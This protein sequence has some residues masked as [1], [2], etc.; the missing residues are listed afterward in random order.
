MSVSPLYA[1]AG[2]RSR[3][4]VVVTRNASVYSEIARTM[5]AIGSDRVVHMSPTQLLKTKGA[6]FWVIDA[7]V[8]GAQDLIRELLTSKRTEGL[9]L[10]SPMLASFNRFCVRVG[11]PALLMHAAVEAP[12]REDRP[13]SLTNREVEIVRLI[14]F[15]R[16]NDEI[17]D[18]LGIT[19]LTVKSH[20]ARMLRKSGARDRCHLVLLA[21]RAR[22]IE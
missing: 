13:L 12:A 3:P 9:V 14:S 17:G 1:T 21:L 15:G 16:T 22:L 11:V 8:S 20:I 6:V 19:G 4:T 18:A 2:I 5:T 10:S 7:R